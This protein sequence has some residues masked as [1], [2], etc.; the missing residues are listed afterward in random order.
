MASTAAIVICSIAAFESLLILTAN[1]FTVYIFWSHRNKLKRTSFLL[2]NLAVADLLIG[3][4]EP[5]AVGTVG[6]PQRFGQEFYGNVSTAF[7]AMFA[8]TSVVCLVLIS[9]ERAFALICPFRHR[10]ISTRAYIYSIIFVWFSGITVGAFTLLAVNGIVDFIHWIVAYCC[11]LA[12]CLLTIC[13]T[14][15]IVRRKVNTCRLDPTMVK[16]HSENRPDG[17]KHST[18]LS[19]TLFIMIAVSLGFWL[20]STVIFSVHSLC[21]R[22]V[23]IPLI[24]ASTV[25]H[26]ANSLVNPV[27]YSFRLPIFREA[28]GKLK[29]KKKQ[30]QSKEYVI[31]W[32]S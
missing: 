13:V 12:S 1:T 3:F 18:K 25:L 31:S 32:H 20:P 29:L 6:I 10:V 27:I 16:N 2:I 24:Y 9:L 21:H 11:I 15:L 8:T 23:P 7:Q 17:E 4:T 26:L 19:R 28:V 14:Y 30:K 5:V 22:C